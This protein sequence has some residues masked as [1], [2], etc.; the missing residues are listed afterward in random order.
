MAFRLSRT[1]FARMATPA[2]RIGGRNAPR[3]AMSSGSHGSQ[4][5]D[6]AWII[7]SA[8]VFGPAALYLLSPSANKKAHKAYQ[9]SLPKKRVSHPEDAPV[10]TTPPPQIHTPVEPVP[11]AASVVTDDE[12]TPASSEEVTES[13]NKSIEED[14]PKEAIVAEASETTEAPTPAEPSESPAEEADPEKTEAP[15]AATSSVEAKSE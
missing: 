1:A 10:P 4:G 5:S 6:Q 13:I 7:G 15:E 9:A 8:L 3:R 2:A 11:K 14:S 12:G